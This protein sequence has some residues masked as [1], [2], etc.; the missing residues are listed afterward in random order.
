MQWLSYTADGGV[1]SEA[2]GGG[3]SVAFS[4]DQMLKIYVTH[5]IKEQ[6]R[7]IWQLIQVRHPTLTFAAL[8]FC[9]Q[10]AL[11][12]ACSMRWCSCALLSEPPQENTPPPMRSR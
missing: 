1:L 5:R 10:L 2:R 7:R 8:I 9:V 6:G 3:L 4:R 11:Y 12:A